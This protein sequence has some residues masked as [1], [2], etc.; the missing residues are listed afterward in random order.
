MTG[1]GVTDIALLVGFRDPSRFSRVFKEQYGLAPRT[2]RH[3]DLSA[4]LLA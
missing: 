3:S 2:F 4:S 1:V